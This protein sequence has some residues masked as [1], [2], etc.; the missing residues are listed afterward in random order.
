[1][2][3]MMA[4]GVPGVRTLQRIMNTIRTSHDILAKTHYGAVF[5]LHP[6]DYVDQ[7]VIR[8]GYYESEVLEAL[9]QAP[10]NATVWDIGANFGLHG[11]TLKVLRPDLNVIC[12]EASCLQAARIQQNA[13]LNG[14]LV[15]V[16]CLGLGSKPGI[17]ILH[18][19]RNGNPGMGT[20]EPWSE[21]RYDLK[22]TCPIESGDRLIELGLVPQPSAIKLDVE[23]GEADAVRGMGRTLSSGRM[24][25]VAEGGDELQKL[26]ESIGFSNVR[27]L[28]RNE[29]TAHNLSNFLAVRDS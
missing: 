26:L 9:L 3:N 17:R 6:D 12:F 23:G 19:M 18:T 28:E 8:H 24:L 22:L 11:V 29:P 16:I 20:F 1:M 21:A 7:I 25:L 13:D 4:L 15:Q 10:P 5:R 2:T 14:V 27:K